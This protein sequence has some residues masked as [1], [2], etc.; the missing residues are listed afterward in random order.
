V[1]RPS[2]RLGVPEPGYYGELLNSD[3]AIYGGSNLGN[4]GGVRSDPIARHGFDQS[5]DLTVPPLACL[6]L[7]RQP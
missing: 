6:F 1:P 4:A 2:Y 3:S 5:I 7:K